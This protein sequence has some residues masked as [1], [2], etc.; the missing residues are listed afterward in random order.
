ML[1]DCSSIADMPVD[2]ANALEH[3]VRIISWQENLTSDDIPPKWMWPLEW[4]L[5]LW[6]VEVDRRRQ[7]ASNGGSGDEQVEMMDNEYARALRDSD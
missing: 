7:S 1:G 4:E 2:L 5:E 6:F 3:A